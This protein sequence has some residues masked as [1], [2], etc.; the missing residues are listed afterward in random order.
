MEVVDYSE[1]SL[2]DSA[3][4]QQSLIANS[5]RFC[6]FLLLQII[7][8]SEIFSAI[9]HLAQ[10]RIGDE[11]FCH[12]SGPFLTWSSAW[13]YSVGAEED[14]P[15][16][17]QRR[18]VLAV[19]PAREPARIDFDQLSNILPCTKRPERVE[20]GNLFP[21]LPLTS[22][23]RPEVSQYASTTSLNVAVL[24]LNIFWHCPWAAPTA[25]SDHV[26]CA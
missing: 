23:E 21:P 12:F 24:I 13:L 26:R 2:A 14:R 20:W 15:P 4:I 11:R 18:T 6:R 1:N 19:S 7:D 17:R 3:M 9:Q 5:R 16:W 10:F 22:E 8:T 25:R